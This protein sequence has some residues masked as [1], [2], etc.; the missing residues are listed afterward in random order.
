MG[1][2]RY[3]YKISDILND[4]LK[5]SDIIESANQIFSKKFVRQVV[6]PKNG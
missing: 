1:D 4:E 2:W 6:K 5:L 3:S